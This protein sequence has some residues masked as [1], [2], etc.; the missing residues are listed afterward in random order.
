MIDVDIT[1]RFLVVG[2]LLLLFA[3]T[4]IRFSWT[5]ERNDKPVTSA[6]MS[7]IIEPGV[8]LEN[9]KPITV[10]KKLQ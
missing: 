2:A 9:Y 3:L 4:V 10:K 6:S 7:Q 8:L 5:V 1:I